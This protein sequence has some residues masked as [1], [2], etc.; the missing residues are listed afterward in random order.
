MHDLIQD[1]R[2]SL[3]RLLAAPGFTTLVVLTFA[4]GIGANTTLFT[5]FDR[6]FLRPLPVE[7]PDR[8]V[9]LHGPGS[10]MGFVTMSKTTPMTMSHP[11]Y[12]DFRDK[13]QKLDGVL[14]YYTTS[15]HATVGA[16]PER[17]T[18]TLVTGTYFDVLGVEAARGRVLGPADDE[19]AGGHPVVV[20]SHDYWQARFGGAEDVLGR[21][22]RINDTAMTI[23]GVAPKGFR[24]LD[25]D[26]VP[27]VYVP[28]AMKKAVT[29]T[30]DHLENRRA[31][32][33]IVFA[34]LADGVSRD[35]AQAALN[36]LYSQILREE[37][38]EI[39]NPSERFRERFLSKTLQLL[40]GRAG[41]S[42]FRDTAGTALKVLI[43]TSAVVLLIA[44]LNVANLLFV[45]ATR[46]HKEMAVRLALGARRGRIVRQLVVEG[47]VLALLGAAAGLM[48]ASV[49][50]PLLT[51]FV[52][53][54]EAQQA[55]AGGL[56]LRVLAYTLAVALACIVIAALAPAW[57]ATRVS[58]SP[59][60]REGSGATSVGGQKLRHALVVAQVALSLALVFGAGLLGRTLAQ[61][62]RTSPGFSVE[63]LL[64]FSVSPVLSG[65]DG[66]QVPQLIARML[67]EVRAAPGV[68]AV[69]AAEEPILANSTSQMTVSVPG[70]EPGPDEDMNPVINSVTPDFISTMGLTLL[71]GRPFDSRDTEGG[72]QVVIVN[73]NFARHFFKGDALGRQIRMGRDEKDIEI[74]G[75]VSNYKHDSLREDPTRRMILRPY[76]QREDQGPLGGMTFY[77][78]V[79]GSEP[80]AIA[81]V[82]EAVRRVEPTLPIY[83]IKTMLDQ[84]QQTMV[85]ERSSAFIAGAF[86][87]VALLLA[88]MGLYGTLSHGVAQRLR[89]IGVRLALGAEPRTI[90]TMIVGQAGRLVLIGL[91]LGIPL[92]Y[93][94]TTLVRTQLF[95]VEAYDPMVTVGTLVALVLSAALA[96]VLPAR[97]AAATDPAATLRCE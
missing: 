32:W 34:R 16:Q 56:D 40:P 83:D 73:E 21:E 48:V 86:A 54:A 97:R 6:A 76:T 51:R 58:L 28:M 65:Y 24:G 67:D 87:A 33:L 94:L 10:T 26:R 84:R 53:D 95:G 85:A 36:G 25:T 89:E 93:A 78:R 3:R 17:T 31:M 39:P 96:A 62:A 69:A 72:Q 20:L 55:L 45:R 88:G 47:A 49:G 37:I 27:N 2:V 90:V 77:A 74:V 71:A 91:V 63:R 44:C 52:P 59:A 61:V 23:V 4:L 22:I 57:H 41:A 70:Y 1:L 14:A 81:A 12:K 46:R 38:A 60:L 29:P 35:E 11:M 68:A 30:W 50:L 80:Q 19:T 43:T 82:R 15:I 18:A 9:M 75:I 79:Q 64:A 13:G 8:L 5:F 66:E 92:A 7:D 42:G